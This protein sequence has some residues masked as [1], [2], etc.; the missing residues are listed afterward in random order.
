MKMENLVPAPHQGTVRTIF[1]AEGDT[2]GEG[3]PL[4]LVARPEMT[5]L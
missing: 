5:T 4:V 3:D 2:V 1:V